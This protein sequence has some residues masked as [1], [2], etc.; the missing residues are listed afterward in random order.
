LITEKTITNRFAPQTF[1]LYLPLLVTFA[2]LLFDFDDCLFATADDRA[3]NTVRTL[4]EAGYAH[5]VFEKARA[6][7]GSET[8]LRMM[9]TAGIDDDEI[10]HRLATLYEE[11][12]RRQGYPKAVPYPEIL[13]TL[14]TLHDFPMGIFS[15]SLREVIVGVL[16]RHGLLDRFEAIVGLEDAEPKPSPEGLFKLC[17]RMKI[18]PKDCLFIGDN[19]K[20]IKTGKAAGTKT[21]AVLHGIGTLEDLKKEE[22]DYILNRFSDLIS[23]ARKG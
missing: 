16:D 20:D 22:P 10:G 2:A 21:A 18:D 7:I 3:W 9:T 15:A 12:N 6:A 11:T 1:L 14:D 17:A 4:H 8:A 23:I 5:V 19:P 13:E